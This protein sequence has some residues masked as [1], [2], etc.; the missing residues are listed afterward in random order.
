MTKSKTLSNKK[1]RTT[2]LKSLFAVLGVATISASVAS[3]VTSC[4]C[5]NQEW[6][7]RGVFRFDKKTG[8][9]LLG[10]KPDI[11]AEEIE[12]AFPNHIM[13]LPNDFDNIDKY[14][15]CNQTTGKSTISNWITG[16]DFGANSSCQLIDNY[17]FKN[18][19]FTGEIKFPKS[20]VAI[21][22]GAFENNTKITKIYFPDSI[23]TVGEGA[24]KNCTELDNLDF[25]EWKKLPE[26]WADASDIFTGCLERSDRSGYFILAGPD[27]VENYQSFCAQWKAFFT[28][29]YHFVFGPD[30][31]KHWKI[32]PDDLESEIFDISYRYDEPSKKLVVTLKGFAPDFDPSTEEGAKKL[33]EYMK[34]I[35]SADDVFKIPPQVTEIA[36]GAF[37][38]PL[39]RITPSVDYKTLEINETCEIIG[40]G[41]F[42]DLTGINTIRFSSDSVKLIGEEAFKK[43]GTVFDIYVDKYKEVP[44]WGEHKIFSGL[45]PTPH[46]S[47][48][49]D[50]GGRVFTN[51]MNT[52]EKW[53]DKMQLVWTGDKELTWSKIE[54]HTIPDSSTV[55]DI[56]DTG[57]I[58]RGWKTGVSKEDILAEFGTVLSIPENI[59]FINP[60]AF[61]DRDKY[62]ATGEVVSTIP[63]ELKTLEFHNPGLG[64]RVS[65][66]KEIRSRAFMNSPI[67][68]VQMPI[69]KNFQVIGDFAFYGSQ[70]KSADLP[71]IEERVVYLK[72]GTS[73]FANTKLENNNGYIIPDYVSEIGSQAFYHARLTNVVFETKPVSVGGHLDT[74]GSAAF[75]YNNGFGDNDGLNKIDLSSWGATP[76]TFGS[77]YYSHIFGRCSEIGKVYLANEFSDESWDLWLF[78]NG[79]SIEPKY[80]QI[81][82]K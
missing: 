28:T 52:S 39:G 70:V 62:K 66:L 1:T 22:I 81:E 45:P 13:V 46:A 73:A 79:I 55:L 3:L 5:S 67:T 10:F 26:R 54:W 20:V 76:P 78:N 35:T 75:G 37:P 53:K 34:S 59:E 32:Q 68:T 72:I 11:T 50:E 18:A 15:F 58:V 16:I 65:N 64:P 24:F 21:G 23:A 57:K 43:C 17:A 60:D 6:V 31:N 56:D 74:I 63:D 14:A 8:R 4:S 71:E 29:R 12:K 19:P 80:W 2:V 33:H 42:G 27:V 61:I 41:A 25:S 7:V 44:Q 47:G 36:P 49:K 38:G 30:K 51:S 69:N 77:T 9:T 40:N 82:K 48:L